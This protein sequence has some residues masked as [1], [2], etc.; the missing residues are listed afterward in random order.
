MA[1]TVEQAEFSAPNVRRKALIAVNRATMATEIDF[2]EYGA[3]AFD[4]PIEHG[5]SEGARG[6]LPRFRSIKVEAT[7]RTNKS[8]GRPRAVAEET[9]ARCPVC[10][11]SE[12]ASA[13]VEFAWIGALAND[14]SIAALED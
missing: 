14:R 9:G 11:L 8:E 6:I 4:D 1:K 2:S 13:H 5:G 3:V 12:N 10:N 7:V